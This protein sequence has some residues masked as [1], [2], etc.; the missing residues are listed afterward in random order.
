MYGHAY[1]L[2]QSPRGATKAAIKRAS[3]RAR[4]KMQALDKKTEQQLTAIYRQAAEDIR[5]YLIFRAGEESLRIEVMQDL[6]NQAE[7]IL[8]GMAATR[9][10][11]LE[12]G[13]QQAADLGVEPFAASLGA[14]NNLTSIADEAALFVTQFIAEDGL[15]LSQR[16]WNLDAQAREVVAQAIQQ[17]VVKGWSSS[18]AA[19]EF[20]SRGLPVPK[21]I[22]AKL[23]NA[24]GSQA[25]KQVV[26]GLMR[27]NGSP[28]DNALRL[29]RTE[30]NRA[31]GEA[32]QAAAFDHPD[33][34]GTRFLLSPNH[35]RVDICD[36]HA[37]LNRY[38][39]GPG[40]YPK[41]KNPWP[42]HPN[43]LSF[44]EVVFADEISQAD[45]EIQQD[46]I[47]WLNNQSKQ[48]QIDILGGIKKQWALDQG[49][50]TK[51]QITSTWDSIKKRLERKGINTDEID[52]SS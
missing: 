38:G 47:D 45:S 25:G 4:A 17:A 6:L 39:L 9:N 2:Q 29:F 27:G 34:I 48:R 42:A 33:V 43:T 3:Q 26:D 11:L 14:S 13:L 8:N 36:M 20:L 30:I 24:T 21:E 10:S 40:V 5:A 44:I 12:T 16:I 23:K 31:H 49:Y 18:K 19:E 28:I 32:Y 50:L 52:R 41:G 37:K 7:T 22:Q 35:P 1:Q 15:Q 46:P 51:N